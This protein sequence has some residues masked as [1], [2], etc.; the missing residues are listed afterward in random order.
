ML[1]QL[2]TSENDAG[3]YGT[4]AGQGPA[5]LLANGLVERL[6][7]GGNRVEVV[8]V[9]PRDPLPTE[10]STAFTSAAGLAQQV[11]S[12][13]RQRRF[14]LVLSGNCMAS[15]GVLAGLRP[16]R[17]GMIWIDPVGDLERPHTTRSGVLDRMA[18]SIILGH[19]WQ[20]MAGAV[21][22]FSPLE[23]EQLLL[24]GGEE[25]D[26]PEA[27]WARE[28]ALP[29]LEFS[30]VQ[31]NGGAVAAGIE[32]LKGAADRIHLHID[33]RSVT[34]AAPGTGQRLGNAEL[35][36]LVRQVKSGVVIASATLASYDPALDP[37]GERGRAA[38][39]IIHAI[40]DP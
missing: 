12:A 5:Y 8:P 30:A 14:P 7:A 40:V 17:R 37:A 35:L 9:A 22:G 1:I 32:R 27:L 11:R 25:M 23:P 18:L 3:R 33:L 34:P 28:M 10:I 21:P 6:E 20:E 38:I 36:E 26:P 15:L 24:I 19:A 39:D 31:R 13:S 2:I 29:W 4:A 16:G